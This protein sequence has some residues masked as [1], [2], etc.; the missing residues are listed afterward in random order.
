MVVVVDGGGAGSSG[1]FGV[2][3]WLSLLWYSG[4]DGNIPNLFNTAVV[5]HLLHSKQKYAYN[6]HNTTH[7]QLDIGNTFA[8]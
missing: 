3:L 6:T 8:E 5:T 2:V 4:N 7:I 1:T